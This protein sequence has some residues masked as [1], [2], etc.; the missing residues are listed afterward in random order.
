MVQLHE[1]DRT[2][3][4]QAKKREEL[5]SLTLEEISAVEDDGVASQEL[6]L[7]FQLC[8]FGKKCPSSR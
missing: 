1:S 3:H 7:F 5:V 8:T 2:T 6:G 4:P